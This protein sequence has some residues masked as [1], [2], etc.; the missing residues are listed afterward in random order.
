MNGLIRSILPT[1][2]CLTLGLG[3]TSVI[4]E[5]QCK[6]KSKSACSSDGSCTWVK[7]YVNK[8]GKKVDP[9]CRVKAKKKKT[10]EKKSASKQQGKQ[11]DKRKLKAKSNHSER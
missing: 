2:I 8:A 1:V 7:G 9:Y 4:A 10:G 11:S 5:G 3:S 6:G